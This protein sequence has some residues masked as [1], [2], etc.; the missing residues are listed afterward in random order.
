MPNNEGFIDRAAEAYSTA[1]QTLISA[2]LAV[3]QAALEFDPFEM[4]ARTVGTAASHVRQGG[5]GHEAAMSAKLHELGTKLSAA[6]QHYVVLKRQTDELVSQIQSAK[7]E[8]AG[9]AQII[10]ATGQV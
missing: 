1:S 6:H 8:L 7:G 2:P 5:G 3:L 9:V 10:G 4:V